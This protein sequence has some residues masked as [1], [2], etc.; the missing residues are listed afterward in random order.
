MAVSS[1]HYQQAWEMANCVI[2]LRLTA[3]RSQIWKLEFVQMLHASWLLLHAV[4]LL[5]C[6]RVKLCP[7]FARDSKTEGHMR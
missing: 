7:P 5:Y 4:R 6:G 1:V 3:C 2:A